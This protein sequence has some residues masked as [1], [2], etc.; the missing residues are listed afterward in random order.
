MSN[1]NNVNEA[2]NKLCQSKRSVK[3]VPNLSHTARSKIAFFTSQVEMH[4]FEG[5]N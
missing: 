2:E 4:L 1:V 3:I 5:P